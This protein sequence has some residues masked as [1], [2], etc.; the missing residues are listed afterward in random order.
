MKKFLKIGGITLLVLLVIIIALPFFLKD[1]IAGEVKKAINE[2]VNA[3]INFGD[4][5]LSLIRDFP[6][7]NLRIDSISVK[8]LA[9]FEGVELARIGQF[10][11]SINL[12]SAFS[13]NIKILE[14][15]IIDP[16][17]DVRVLADGSA[18]YDIA[19]ASADTSATP[20]PESTEASAFNLELKHLFVRNAIVKYD[21]ATMPFSME[22]SGLNHDLEGDFGAE[23][24]TMTTKTTAEKVDVVYD[25]IRYLK[26]VKSDI[27]A[28]F[29]VNLKD[30]MFKFMNNTIFVNELELK[31]EGWIAMPADDIDMDISFAAPGTSFKQLLSLVPAEFA[32]DLS[33]VDVSGNMN[34][35]GF[36]RGKFNDTSMPGFGINLMVENG[37]F[38]YP[39]LPKSAE[40]IQIKASIDA[41]DGNDY[42]KMK[43]DIDRF[44]VELA[45]NPVDATLKLRTPMSDPDI[46]CT[47]KSQLD[48][49][50]VKDVVPMEG[51][52][53]TGQIT[54]DIGLKGKMSSI[55]QER[56][57]EFDA[58]GQLIL[59][60][61]LYKDDS[62]A[63][64]TNIE[65]AYFNF[66]PQFLDLSQFKAQIGRSDIQANGK[67]DNYLAYY[68]KDSL[69]S[70]T[71][72][73]N[74]NLLDLNEFME[75]SDEET[76][77]APADS[78]SEE[79]LSVIRVPKNIDF[80]M[81]TSI[82]TM[83]YDNLEIKNV[84][85]RVKVAEGVARLEN[86]GMNM[87]DGAIT[88]NGTYDTREEEPYVD[89]KYD[90]R[91]LDIKKT[92][93]SFEII[94]TM[95]PIAKKCSGKFSTAMF[96]KS[97]L[98][99]AMEPIEPTISGNGSLS[100][101]SVYVEG[102]EPLMKVAESLKIDKLSKQTIQD[103]S[104]TYKIEDGKAI[105][106]PYTIKLD[107]IPTTIAGYTT[108]SQEINYTVDMEIPFE[109]LGSKAGDMANDLLAQFN[110]KTGANLKAGQ[111][112]PVNLKIGGTVTEPKIQSN[113]GDSVGEATDNLID[114]AKDQIKEEVNAKIEE[115]KEEAIKKA[116]EEADKIL[117]DAQAQA[118]KLVKDAK[119]QAEK[120]K[121]EG[122]KQASDLEKNA[123]GPIEKAG[124]KIAADKIRKESDAS[125]V[126]IEAEAKKQADAIMATARKKADD[127]I[128]S[129]E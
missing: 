98:N 56:Y 46:D 107:G 45:N 21:D 106:D 81:S 44:H 30:M 91:D 60:Q 15:G 108:F 4:V 61:F 17:I 35:D 93:E 95:A 122:Y 80:S 68:L 22:I 100:A 94:A 27:T 28:D 48:L 113:Y 87:L 40:N 55:E 42:D 52:E 110:K 69:L 119:T 9:P 129:V 49:A 121:A 54:A 38:K 31:A 5:S 74:S 101:K 8:N 51:S 23:Q 123:K 82:G 64:T 63:Y 14:V 11:T 72:N 39:D 88:M 117:A 97:R 37:R 109:K 89:F 3:E 57:E 70:G 66:S 24:M 114:Q 53:L 84:N 115:G 73:L 103:V 116:R 96:L 124:A 105:V 104:L 127:K 126:K 78:S 7:L 34:F 112:I 77:A 59:Q 19:K 62:L 20:E 86:L 99:Q 26:Q 120:V 10:E 125:A 47:I 118:D 67:I 32:S 12:M 18:N 1:K 33:G 13:D 65:A 2:Q 25:G 92:T 76:A 58:H 29:D 90:I 36:V 75:D 83:L 43:L 102:F 111:K 79:P 128:K 41:S 6:R 16:V 71:F 85:G 50:T